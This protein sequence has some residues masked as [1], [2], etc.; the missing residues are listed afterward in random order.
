MEADGVLA[1]YKTVL[2]FR[3]KKQQQKKFDL[4][5]SVD[6]LQ[7]QRLEILN[8]TIFFKFPFLNDF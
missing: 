4:K 7:L 5:S 2:I 3:K 6:G 8:N 1:K